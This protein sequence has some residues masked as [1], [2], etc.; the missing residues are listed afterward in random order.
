MWC[1]LHEDAF[2]Y[3]GG[4]TR[5]IRQD[6]SRKA[7]SRPTSTIQKSTSCSGDDG[8]LRHD[9]VSMP[10]VAPNLKGKVES[11][12]DYVQGALKGKRFEKT[13]EQNACLQRWNESWGST[14]IH[15]TTKRQ[16]REMFN[17]E[18][19]HLLPLPL[20]RFEYY[21]ARNGAFI[22]TGISKCRTLTIRFHYA[23]LERKWLSTL[24]GC[25]C[26]FSTNRRTS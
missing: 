21:R 8:T 4:V 2:A 19:P 12:I 20:T 9:C 25:G 18:R 11:G 1:E 5:M 3:I 7:C 23:T 6:N 10:A 26:V 14:R 22:S 15:G 17:E 16:V 24:G 13:E